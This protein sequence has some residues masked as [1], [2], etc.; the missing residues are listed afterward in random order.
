MLFDQQDRRVALVDFRDDREHLPA[1]T[2]ATVRQAADI[3]AAPQALHLRLR[4]R[5]QLISRELPHKR[6]RE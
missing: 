1:Q 4:L 5:L 3:G 6:G 2:Q